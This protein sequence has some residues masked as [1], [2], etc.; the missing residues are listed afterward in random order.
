MTGTTEAQ[1]LIGQIEAV[2]QTEIGRNIGAL[3]AAASGGLWSAAT[4]L[5]TAPACRV[6]LI[7]GFYV[8]SGAPPAAETDGPVG[9]ALLARG[10]V[11]SGIACRLATDDPCRNACAV[12]LA[13]A[14]AAAV[15]VDAAA[16]GAS[17][18]PLID[19]WRAAGITH[20]I[21]IER[22][23]RSADGMPRNMRGQDI[24]AHT[25]ALDE[26]FAAGPWDTIAIGDGGNEIGMGALPRDLIARHVAMGEAIACVTPA[27]HLIVAGV[28]H[29]GAYALL[30]ALAVLRRD[31]RA[32]MFGAL[33][34]ALDRRVLEATLVDGPA[35]D[36]VS[37]VQAPTIDNL[38]LGTHHRKLRQIRALA[39]G[40][41]AL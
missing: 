13:A 11:A 36:G 29:W 27:R 19:A 8:P 25:A 14:G 39:E 2:V 40:S 33:D 7:T 4:A 5:G 17:L 31:W 34:E 16:V 9:A 26:L 10:L 3:C 35:V 32:G 41:H 37:R 23:G 21:A 18:A 30:G 12:A 15:P 6:G 24:A 1:A 28:S 22:C 38:D 20:A